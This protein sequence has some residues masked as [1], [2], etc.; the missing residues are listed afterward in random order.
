MIEGYGEDRMVKNVRFE[1]L[2]ING[3][4]ITDDMPGKPG[5]YNT[6]DMARIY[7]GPHVENVTFVS[8]EGENKK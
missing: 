7:V 6:G 1:N 4:L 3:R 5:W 8:T 2:R